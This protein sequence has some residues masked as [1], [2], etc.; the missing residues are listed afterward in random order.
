MDDRK[1]PNMNKFKMCFSYI[2]NNS[3]AISQRYFS[4]YFFLISFSYQ[5]ISVA[6]SKCD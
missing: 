2:S 6:N 4:Q 3:F 5:S 1:Q